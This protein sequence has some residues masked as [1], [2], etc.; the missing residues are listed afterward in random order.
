MLEN[1]ALMRLVQPWKA[2]EFILVT[3]SGIVM[4]VRPEQPEKVRSLMV[5]TLLG[6]LM[7]LILEQP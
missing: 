4:D 3:L 6:M 7:F 2:A 1:S 5:V